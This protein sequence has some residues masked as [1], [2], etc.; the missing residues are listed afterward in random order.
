MNKDASIIEV[1]SRLNLDGRG[2][3]AVDHWDGDRMALGI[4]RTDDPR[5]LVYI[6]TFDRPHGRYYFECEEPVGAADDEFTISL[7]R[8]NASFEE[9]LS[10]LEHH[11]RNR[12]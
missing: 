2:W 1:V 7:C 6:S 9:L 4:A 8:E 3:T 12:H 10:A 11:L 5:R